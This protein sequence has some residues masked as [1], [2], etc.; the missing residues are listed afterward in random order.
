MSEN[1]RTA[2]AEKARRQNKAGQA[3]GVH[4]FGTV[5]RKTSDTS[6]S[7]CGLE[8]DTSLSQDFVEANAAM[9]KA[10]TH[11][12]AAKVYQSEWTQHLFSDDNRSARINIR[13]ITPRTA[14]ELKSALK[15]SRGDGGPD[16][17]DIRHVYINREAIGKKSQ[18]DLEIVPPRDGRP[19]YVTVESGLPNL[20]IKSGEAHV[21]MDSVWGNTIHVKDSA[22]VKLRVGADRK[23]RGYATDGGTLD[24]TAIGKYPNVMVSPRYAGDSIL[25]HVTLTKVDNWPTDKFQ[26]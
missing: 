1:A 23:F 11:T 13:H 17:S 10:V 3:Q 25:G 6:L 8:A 26:N 15:N 20:V 16:A 4:G 19:I 24:V 2:A 21:V 22:K 14:A 5:A 7:N 9:D 12:T 18:G